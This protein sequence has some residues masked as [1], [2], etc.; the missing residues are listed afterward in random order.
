MFRRHYDG[1]E[2][3][4]NGEAYFRLPP[5]RET[6]ATNISPETFLRLLGDHLASGID[7]TGTPPAHSLPIDI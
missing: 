3:R 4:A 1:V 6:T 5:R 7:G 2:T